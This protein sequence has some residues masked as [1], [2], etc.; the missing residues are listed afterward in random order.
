ML[1]LCTLMHDNSFHPIGLAEEP[2]DKFVNQKSPYRVVPWGELWGGLVGNYR[3]GYYNDNIDKEDGWVWDREKAI[4]RIMDGADKP[5]GVEIIN[6]VIS[7]KPSYYKQIKQF[8]EWLK[9]S[10]GDK[11]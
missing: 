6:K 4:Q 5:D 9:N 8:N 2:S 3:Q 1:S 10:E 7:P 11:E